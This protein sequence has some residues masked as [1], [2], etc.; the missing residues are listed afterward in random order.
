M[1]DDPSLLL[2]YPT[3][4]SVLPR[5]RQHH[6]SL[7]FHCNAAGCNHLLTLCLVFICRWLVAR[8]QQS[9]W[10]WHTHV[11]QTLTRSAPVN[12]MT[13]RSHMLPAA[14]WI[15]R[16]RPAWLLNVPCKVMCVALCGTHFAWW[17]FRSS[18]WR[19]C[20]EFLFF[21]SARCA[22]CWGT[23]PP[24]VS[25]ACYATWIVVCCLP[26]G[27]LVSSHGSFRNWSVV[28]TGLIHFALI[29]SSVLLSVLLL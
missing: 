22:L 2:C 6:I 20:A 26:C 10:H 17:L 19:R 24:V 9:H 13:M 7:A 3:G 5:R 23:R 15:V 21:Q 16:C 18:R 12:L 25:G 27:R 11:K 14:V 28:G 29:R 4:L 1:P 8:P